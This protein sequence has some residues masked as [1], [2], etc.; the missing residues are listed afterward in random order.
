MITEVLPNR[1]AVNTDLVVT[2]SIDDC[3]PLSIFLQLTTGDIQK[4][5]FKDE[6]ELI[7]VWHKLIKI[8]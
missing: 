3:Y 5:V 7:E 8:Y 2:V 4:L 6:G 1:L